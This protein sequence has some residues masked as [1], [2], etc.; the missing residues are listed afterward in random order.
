MQKILSV[1]L[2]LLVSAYL[3]A[4]Q[5]LPNPTTSS[6]QTM[7]AHIPSPTPITKVVDWSKIATHSKDTI[8][9]NYPD[10]GRMD[11]E[12]F[13]ETMTSSLMA[14]NHVSKAQAMRILA[15]QHAIH[16][17]PL[18]DSLQSQLGDDLAHISWGFGTPDRLS[19]T[20]QSQSGRDDDVIADYRLMV[21][22]KANVKPDTYHLVFHEGHAKGFSLPVQIL[23]TA[24]RT[25][26]EISA[27]YNDDSTLQKIKTIINR[28]HG[29]MQGIGIGSMQRVG[30]SVS[31]AGDLPDEATF[32]KLE[33]E[34]SQLTDLDIY[35]ERQS[36][37]ISPL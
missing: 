32:L 21:L 23:P 20:S 13:D 6:P 9:N 5:S 28:H 14:D 12:V 29:Q 17:T 31:F 18:F 35:V 15:I 1:G 27:I 2:A 22:T 25:D 10:V 7:P 37:T 3:S 16:D 4:C 36:I 19:I 24:K 34:L 33:Q 11:T 8:I 30:V 26:D